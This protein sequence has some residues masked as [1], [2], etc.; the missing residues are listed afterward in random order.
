MALEWLLMTKAT[1]DSCQRELALNNNIA[2][3]KNEA[4]ATKALKEMEVC[5]A[6]M[7]TEVEAYWAI[8]ACTLEKSHKESML[9]LEHEAIAEEE[10][11]C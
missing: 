5:Y 6:T 8:H 10:W 11:D 9:E 2:R 1:M 7:I 4:W 3:C